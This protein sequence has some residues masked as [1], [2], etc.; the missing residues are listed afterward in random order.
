MTQDLQREY[1]VIEPTHLKRKLLLTATLLALARASGAA[2]PGNTP[3]N[4]DLQKQIE[5]LKAAVETLQQQLNQKISTAPGEPS[6]PVTSET[7]VAPLATPATTQ[8]PTPATRDD[9]D[10][11]RADL[12]NYKYENERNR[13]R[14]TLQTNRT[15]TITGTL[16]TRW[17][18]QLNGKNSDSD[19]IVG[20]TSGS[21]GGQN[22]SGNSQNDP[23]P[24]AGRKSSF[25]VPLATL[26]FAGKL[27]RDYQEGK[28]LEYKLGFS[29]TPN[30]NSGVAGT[31][32][33]NQGSSTSATFNNGSQFNLTDAYLLY[34]YFPTT[35]G[36]EENKGTLTFG[37]Q[38]IPFGL[39][40]QIGEELKP[41]I[42]QA[43]F[44]NGLGVGTRQI[45]L[46]ARGDVLPYVDYTNNYRAPLLEY[47][48]G[49][50]NG[51]GMNKSDD[52]NKK[53]YLGRLAFTL[54][55]DYAS[56]FREL[57]F[58]TSVYVGHR[59][60]VG[61]SA[62]TGNYYVLSEDG[63]NARH[64]F[65]IYYNHTPF[66]ITYEYVTGKDTLLTGATETSDTLVKSR[67]QT[68]TTSL[69]WGEQF[70]ASSKTVARYD[71]FWPKS[72]QLFFRYDVWDPNTYVS[73][74]STKIYTLGLNLFF[75]QTTKLQINLA[76]THNQAP[77]ASVARSSNAL[78]TQ[79]QYGF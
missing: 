72:T 62:A 48:F 16:Q 53:D 4:A 76:H 20:N 27:F 46:I 54:P 42:N 69:I 28:N 50:V 19:R 13:E 67:G 66:N 60:V 56:I 35:T 10:G 71:D 2:E 55:V 5:Q 64:G 57:K 52:N 49:V 36:G 26:S 75:A 41:V 8:T 1:F 40:A 45:G 11:L 6:K 65:D 24:A 34:N 7:T 39:E 79:F 37:Q 14:T 61:H 73:Y 59:N 51:S 12:E 30:V 18:Y 63:K 43:Q 3:S 29:Y 47:A 70:I 17:T 21:T 31:Q 44:V 23:N 38:L 25:D 33:A 58:G 32:T 78:L 15:T 77:S 74:N 22:T 9:I 68:L